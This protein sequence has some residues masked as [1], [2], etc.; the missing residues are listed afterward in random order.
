MKIARFDSLQARLLLLLLGLVT[1]IWLAAASL[2]WYD[3]S[4]ELDELLETGTELVVVD[5]DT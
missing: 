4:H 1:V 2:T 3:A 5:I